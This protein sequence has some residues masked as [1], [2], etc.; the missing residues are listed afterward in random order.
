MKSRDM[1]EKR[2]RERRKVEQYEIWVS[3]SAKAR[4]S[5]AHKIRR[6][7]N[8]QAGLFANK[9]SPPV[10]QSAGIGPMGG[11]FGGR[12][13]TRYDGNMTRRYSEQVLGACLEFGAS[14]TLKS[15]LRQPRTVPV[16]PLLSSLLDAFTISHARVSLRLLVFL[17]LPA[18]RYVNA[19]RSM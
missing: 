10:K 8:L 2:E 17:F 15:W 7:G 14:T 19:T 5:C 1:R 4:N 18:L 12:D 16:S 11:L 3:R 13:L 6:S 9:I